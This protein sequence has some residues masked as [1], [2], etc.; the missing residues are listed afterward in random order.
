LVGLA[1]KR[2]PQNSEEIIHI[3]GILSL[4]VSRTRKSATFF[5]PELKME[6]IFQENF[7]KK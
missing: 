7:E 4:L 2:K 3:R 1:G 6:K 5:C